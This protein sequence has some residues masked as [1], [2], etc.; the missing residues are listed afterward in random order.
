M[1]TQCYQRLATA[2]G[3]TLL[4]VAAAHC[5]AQTSAP[6]ESLPGDKMIHDYL[7][8]VTDELETDACAGAKTVAEW[9]KLRPGLREQYLYMLGLSPLPER[10]PLRA[11]I[12]GGVSGEGY[13]VDN[14]HFQSRPGLY[15]TANLYRP[16]SVQPG[17]RLPAVLYLCGHA[18]HGRDGNKVVFA[19]FGIWF[20]R[21]GYVC[22][23]LDTLQ[24]GEVP[25]IHHG[26][27][28]ENRW[29]WL[30][31]G[32]TP[33]GV[34]CWNALRA[35]DYLAGRDDVDPERLGVTGI[36]GGGGT[37]W[38]VAGLDERIK[39]AV[40]ISGMADLTCYVKNG[41]IRG[42]CDCMFMYNAFRWPWTR[43][44]AMV[45]PRPVLFANSDRDR[46]FPISSNERIAARIEH[47][48]KLFGAGDL[49]ESMLSIGDHA[50]REDLRKATYRFLNMH[51]KND[52]RVVTDSE[53]DLIA[54]EKDDATY[55]I[56]PAKLRA[57]P[58]DSDVPADAVNGRI[59]ETFVPMAKIDPPGAGEFD[60]W[61]AKLVGELRRVGFGYFPDRVPVGELGDAGMDTHL[62]S[63]RGITVVL[64]GDQAVLKDAKRVV[65]V[66]DTGELA[67]TPILGDA[68]LPTWLSKSL[69]PGDHVVTCFPRS[70]GET[71]WTRSNPPNPIER[72]HLLLG[73][74]VDTG[75]VWDV[76]AAA[77][78]LRVKYQGMPVYL[79][80]RGPGAVL[81]GYA[82]LLEPKLAG[83]IAVDPLP[84]HMDPAA[85]Q[86]LNVLR[87]CDIPEVFGMLAPRPLTITA[88]EKHEGARA[89]DAFARTAAIYAAAGAGTAFHRE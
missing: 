55:P 67:A 50:Y 58:Q 71:R 44:A 76:I 37:S 15:V 21:H 52:A 8:R 38:W 4:G 51:L 42:H 7:A 10:T 74:T 79:L 56:P 5:P 63:E 13:R 25:G 1:R 30:S 83:V 60:A 33:A 14:L 77:R 2:A 68:V 72:S 80:G 89:P 88:A 87:V 65:M 39:V 47:I 40:P 45:A 12:T 29:W 3:L 53:V 28:R 48:W 61:R 57:F 17:Q 66:V 70:V 16:A 27:F 26:T 22:L 20:A 6:A 24:M 59:D 41:F 84:T 49:A 34:E 35:L 69:S 73:R 36:S 32:Y 82:A 19:P 11:T 23:I 31:R 81:A 46:L 54:D 86:F 43:I 18:K 62:Q 9:M 75:K 64:R 85:P 78:Y